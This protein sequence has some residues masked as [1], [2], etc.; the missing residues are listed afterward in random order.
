MKQPDTL[1]RRAQES[2]IAVS[3]STTRRAASLGLRG[4]VASRGGRAR[5]GALSERLRMDAVRRN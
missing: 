2:E 3:R 1:M 4:P 5:A